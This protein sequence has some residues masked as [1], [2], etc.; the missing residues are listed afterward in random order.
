MT[1]AQ[2]LEWLELAG[3]R[4]YRDGYDDQP[5]L[6]RLKLARLLIGPVYGKEDANCLVAAYRMLY[7]IGVEERLADLAEESK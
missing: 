1:R 3:K 2:G 4:A 5:P 7:S 6:S